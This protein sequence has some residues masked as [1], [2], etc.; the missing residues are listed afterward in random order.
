MKGK[1]DGKESKE[2]VCKLIVA[3]K[4]YPA[5]SSYCKR[6]VSPI[7]LIAIDSKHSLSHSTIL[8][9]RFL[10]KIGLLAY[11]MTGMSPI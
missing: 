2:D 10:L 5:A 1:L 4:T 8:D 3:V 7:N 6:R 11:C 9:L